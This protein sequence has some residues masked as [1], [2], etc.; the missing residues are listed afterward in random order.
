MSRRSTKGHEG[1][2]FTH[3]KANSGVRTTEVA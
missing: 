2:R 1:A 3:P